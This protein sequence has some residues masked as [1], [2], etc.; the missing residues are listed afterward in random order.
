MKMKKYIISFA[1]AAM[2]CSC[3]LLDTAPT[4]KIADGNMWS[5]VTLTTAGIDGLMYPFYRQDLS[6][7]S[8]LVKPG[9]T[10]GI[11][12]IYVEGWGYTS[13][14]DGPCNFL[15]NATKN[16]GNDE[17]A[18]EWKS[19]FTAVHACNKAIAHMSEEVVGKALYNQYLCEAK[20]IRA[21]AYTRLVLVFGEVPIYLEET[22][23]VNC[24]KTQDPW[25]D[26]WTMIIKECTECIDNEYFQ[27]NNFSGRL[28]KPSKG[29]AYAIRGNAY[30]WLAANMNPKIYEG[31]AGIDETKSKE[32]YALAAAD[33]AKV[34][35][36]GFDLWKGEWEELFTE[37]NEHN[38]EMIFPLEFST[39]DGY[40]SLWNWVVGSRSN[41]HAW[42]R[43]VPS[44]HFVDDFQWA[45]GSAFNWKQI[46]PKWN[47][48]SAGKREVFFLR[49]S[50]D[51][52][53][54]S[55]ANGCTREK[56]ITLNAEREKAISRIGEEAWA[57]YYLNIGNEA[58][59]LT[60]YEGRD[61]RL[62]KAVV[63]PYKPY[64]MYNDNASSPHNYVRRWPRFK[65]E[66]DVEGS[67]LWMEFASNMVYCWYKNL[68]TDGSILVRYDGIDWPLLRYTQIHLMWAEALLQT[69]DIPGAQ[70]LVNEI[71][72]R[73]GMPD[74]T[75][76]N[77][78]ELMDAI[79][80]ET[81]IELCQEG[82]DF[83]NEI[84]W[85]TFREVKFRNKD[86]IDPHTCWDQGG[87]KTG[88]Y[89]TE[90]MWPLSAPLTEIVRNS[91]LK[92]RPGWAY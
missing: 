72:Q 88:Y 65:R 15:K 57:E 56:V 43:L 40:E 69:G 86:F 5:S 22:D 8:E 25:D 23:N 70:A 37:A 36:C 59:L 71:R 62:A 80:Y 41:L 90:G 49:D 46:F 83:F 17:N 58:R 73:A 16:A 31:A 77:P 20:M 76:S 64:R 38:S 26:V 84:R 60:A 61:P 74:V 3:G 75:T 53:R 32:Y 44:N 35:E 2:C 85:G 6:S 82:K 10:G 13:I 91:N 55:V 45:D 39:V 54:D 87:W 33:F 48:M 18:A 66:D 29:M 34:R 9:G 81:R 19:M 27:T 92:Q 28:Y 42:N 1:L 67:D 51:C 12:R 89:Y 50:L 63:I 4:N 68:I 14:M 21:F 52:F 11:G 47:S 30:M 7:L 78:E 24:N 79:R